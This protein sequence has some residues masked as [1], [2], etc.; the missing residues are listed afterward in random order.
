MPPRTWPL[1]LTL[2]ALSASPPGTAAP[3][4]IGKLAELPVTMAGMRPLVSAKING[5]EARFVADSGAFFSMITPSA[6]AQFKLQPGY[7]L[8]FSD[9]LISGVGGDT[10]AWLTKVNTFT[11]F[12]VPFRDVPFVVAGNEIEGAAGLLGQNVFRLLGAD[13]E[14]DLAHGAIRLWRTHDCR[15]ASL[16]YWTGDPPLPVSVMPIEWATRESP[17]TRGVAFLNGKKIH[18]IFDTGAAASLLALTAAERAGFKPGG[19]GVVPAGL[20]HGV[21]RRVVQTW[22]APF[23]S[24]KI[25]DEEILHTHL[26]VGGELGI[27]DTD[28]LIG[29]DFFLSHRIYVANSQDKLYFTYNG[30]TVFDLTTSPSPH[31]AGGT[32]QQASVEPARTEDEP[33]DAAAFSRRGAA[34]TARHDY[35]HAIADLTRACELAPKEPEYFYLRAIAYWADRQADLA[36]ADFDQVLKLKPDDVPALLGR[37]RLHLP[38]HDPSAALADLDAVD[39][40]VSAQADVRLELGRLYTRAGHLERAIAQFDQWIAAHAGDVQIPD[41]R[42]ARCWARALAGHELD[43]ALGDCDAA[44]KSRP[45][46]AAFLDSRG[47]VRLRLG[48]L[49]RAIADYDASLKVEPR[50]VWSLYGRGLARLRKGLSNDGNAD[51]AA[52]IAIAPHIE[53]EARAYGLTR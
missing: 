7:S 2:L 48:N 10:R 17:H 41:A 50:N 42:N 28:M 37:A 8:E 34:F 19:E 22:I 9:F 11:L 20:S 18:V 46:S 49:D 44:L 45:G 53:E 27:R 13:V 1:A 23:E 40:A 26:R 51:I 3:C 4:K 39:H 6:A 43:K 25:G 29:S 35:E 21:G 32:T 36:G 5:A 52:A 24:F 38:A 33:K 12:D 31:P 16:A 47:L 30:G 15:K 14:Y